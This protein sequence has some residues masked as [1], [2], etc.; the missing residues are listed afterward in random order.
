M[1]KL[2]KYLEYLVYFLIGVILTFVL[3]YTF[4]DLTKFSKI[5]ISTGVSFLFGL[6][7]RFV[8]SFAKSYKYENSESNP[9]FNSNVDNNFVF[10]VISAIGGLLTCLLFLL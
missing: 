3:S 7:V 2:K 4:D 10:A 6:G 1:N 5:L 9:T 8:Y